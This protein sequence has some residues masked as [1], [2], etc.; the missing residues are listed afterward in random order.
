VQTARELKATVQT[1]KAEGITTVRGIA[2][3]LNARGVATPQGKQWHGTSVHR[4]L[5]RVETVI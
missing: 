4:L 1:L 2:D 3:A 5:K